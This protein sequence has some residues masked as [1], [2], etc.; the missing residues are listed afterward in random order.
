[1]MNN[2]NASWRTALFAEGDDVPGIAA[3]TVGHVMAVRT[4]NYFYAEHTS[5]LY[6]S[7]K[8]FYD[9]SNDPY[10]LQSKPNDAGYTSVVN[11]LQSI[12]LTLKSCAGSNCFVTTP[13]PSIVAP[14]VTLTQSSSQT[15]SD[16]AVG[17][18]FTISWT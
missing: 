11:G 12:F 1:L 6:G 17:E 18:Q 3:G 8:E 9:L 10:Q 5:A 4:P 2:A 15:T 16:G 14:T 13:E 7:E